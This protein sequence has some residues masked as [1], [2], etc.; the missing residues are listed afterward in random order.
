MPEWH[1]LIHECTSI[2]E[3]EE[4]DPKSPHDLP[5]RLSERPRRR[6]LRHQ[7]SIDDD[8]M[9]QVEEPDLVEAIPLMCNNN[10]WMRELRHR[11]E[12]RLTQWAK[13]HITTD[14]MV[15]TALNPRLR[16]LPIICTDSER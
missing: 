10:T 11:V 4:E 2:E 8:P 3:D 1:A 14:H 7:K 16:K 15:A 9:L 5:L 13:E 6:S 12:H